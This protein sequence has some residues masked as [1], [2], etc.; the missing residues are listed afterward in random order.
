MDV[1]ISHDPFL[2][3]GHAAPPKAPAEQN[4]QVGG[5]GPGFDALRARRAEVAKADTKP[6]RRRRV[7]KPR[8]A[9]KGASRA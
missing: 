1:T 8:K 9:K 7:P 5:K 3:E 4:G 6:A 2:P